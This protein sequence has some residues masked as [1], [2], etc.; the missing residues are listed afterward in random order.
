MDDHD[1]PVQP[2]T[3]TI[4]NNLLEVFGGLTNQIDFILKYDHHSLPP[5]MTRESL[6]SLISKSGQ[7]VNGTY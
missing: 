1:V 2:H 7:N 5:N 3:Y 6:L 4:E